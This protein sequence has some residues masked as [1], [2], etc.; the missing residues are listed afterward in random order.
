ML[1]FLV[2]YGSIFGVGVG[3]VIKLFIVV[4]RSA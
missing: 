4:Y 2:V 3:Q 1:L